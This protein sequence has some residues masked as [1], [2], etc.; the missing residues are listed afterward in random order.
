MGKPRE[1]LGNKDYAEVCLIWDGWPCK[2]VFN[3][4]KPEVYTKERGNFSYDGW[5][6]CWFPIKVKR[7]L[8]KKAKGLI[9]VSQVMET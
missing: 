2:V 7:K 4:N 8:I 9:L 3:V 6:Y 5:S 1:K